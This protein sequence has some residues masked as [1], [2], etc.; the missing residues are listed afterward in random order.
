MLLGLKEITVHDLK[1]R[2]ESPEPFMLLDVREPVEREICQL[3]N[4]ILIPLGE[5]ADRLAE[6]PEKDAEIV[7]HC[8]V[9]GRSAKALQLLQ[10]AGFTNACHVIGG[11]NAWSE[12]IDETVTLY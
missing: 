7:I 4:S 11:I 3:P 2:M 1:S 12:E 5:L 8:K 6:L 9:G 10:G